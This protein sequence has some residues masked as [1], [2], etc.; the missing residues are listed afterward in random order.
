LSALLG[1]AAMLIVILGETETDRALAS[2]WSHPP[3]EHFV[4]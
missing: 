3:E 2:G 4:A 1:Y